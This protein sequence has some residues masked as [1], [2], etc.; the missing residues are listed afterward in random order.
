M[1][2]NSHTTD[3]LIASAGSKATYTG[4]GAGISAWFLS[5][6]GV[7]LIGI[8]IG[9]A[10]LVVNYYFKRRE[11]SRLQAEHDARMSAIIGARHTRGQL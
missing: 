7:A 2:I 1:H 8:L 10:G 9:L 3:A 6:T 11:D 5:D 4:A